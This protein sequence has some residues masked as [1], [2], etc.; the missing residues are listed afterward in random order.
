MPA[1]ERVDPVQAG[2]PDRPA[3]PAEQLDHARL[4]GELPEGIEVAYDG[5]RLEFSEEPP[6]ALQRPQSRF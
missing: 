3:V 4:A 5:L 6:P 2:N 1:G